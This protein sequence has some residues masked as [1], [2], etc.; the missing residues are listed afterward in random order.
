MN[1]FIELY[2]FEIDPHREKLF[3]IDL[4]DSETIRAKWVFLPYLVRM[5]SFK[6]DR[7][8]D[9]KKKLEKWKSKKIT[10]TLAES[11][12]VRFKGYYQ[13]NCIPK[14]QIAFFHRQGCP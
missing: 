6:N 3:G 12:W 2:I 5:I 1:N 8:S 10:M 7:K 13:K 4:V 9:L 11:S 14:K